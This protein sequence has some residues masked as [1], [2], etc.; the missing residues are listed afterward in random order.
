MALAA[1]DIK[2]SW[3]IYEL[4]AGAGDGAKE[5]TEAAPGT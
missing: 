1:E 2:R 5:K 4:F 3:E